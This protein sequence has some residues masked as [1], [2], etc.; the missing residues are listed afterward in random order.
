MVL[1][2]DLVWRV[3]FAGMSL[4]DGSKQDFV[5]AHDEKAGIANVES[6]QAALM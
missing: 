3:V 5:V 2:G 1:E 4:W 6:V